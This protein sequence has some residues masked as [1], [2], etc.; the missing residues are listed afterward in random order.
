MLRSH[1]SSVIGH[2]LVVRCQSGSTYCLLTSPAVRGRA[3]SRRG[4]GLRL[5]LGAAGGY[6]DPSIRG[7]FKSV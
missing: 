2:L 7:D 5:R 3:A 4:D 1:L 6:A